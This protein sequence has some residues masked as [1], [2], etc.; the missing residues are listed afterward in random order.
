MW[1]TRRAPPS[2]ACQMP[3]CQCLAAEG[4]ESKEGARLEL[5]P[6][7]DLE[8]PATSTRTIP[9]TTQRAK[10]IS[11]SH[12]SQ[13]SLIPGPAQP[14]AANTAPP[15]Q[16]P[17][18]T[19]NPAG[20]HLLLHIGSPHLDTRGHHSLSAAFTSHVKGYLFPAIL[21]LIIPIQQLLPSRPC[22]QD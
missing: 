6:V 18:P 20:T 10:R 15:P 16:A 4:R 22:Q 7:A 17:N 3:R 19:S 5:G 2:I 14:S 9:T 1:N 11:P 21:R 12:A 13:A 8:T